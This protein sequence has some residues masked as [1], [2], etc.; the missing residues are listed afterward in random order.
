MRL[1]FLSLFFTVVASA[2]AQQ[3]SASEQLKQKFIAILKQQLT[4]MAVP[5]AGQMPAEEIARRVDTFATKAVTAYMAALTLP[6]DEANRLLTNGPDDQANMAAM[7]RDIE[8]WKKLER[9]MPL[10]YKQMEDEVKN[11]K[12]KGGLDL[13]L[14]RRISEFHLRQLGLL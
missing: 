13:E 9:P 10:L 6:D 12:I 5:A 8:L 14:T 11:G 1:T 4:E 7:H 3:T 2:L